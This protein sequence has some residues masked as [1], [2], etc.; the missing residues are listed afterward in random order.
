MKVGQ[1]VR[2]KN[3]PEVKGVVVEEGNYDPE[4]C[5]VRLDHKT[6]GYLP[7]LSWYLVES[8]QIIESEPSPQVKSASCYACKHSGQEPDCNMYCGHPDAGLYGVSLLRQPAEHCPN[9]SKF[10]QHPLRPAP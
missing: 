7:G 6:M 5:R 3:F 2:L 9:H 8:L 4:W 10:E 1:L